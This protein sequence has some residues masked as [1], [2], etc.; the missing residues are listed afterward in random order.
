MN[1]DK[2]IEAFDVNSTY[3]KHEQLFAGHII[4]KNVWGL[5]FLSKTFISK[6]NII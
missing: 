1:I 2:I 3:L 5:I 6:N 4:L